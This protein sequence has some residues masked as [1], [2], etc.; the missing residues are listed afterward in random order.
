VLDIRRDRVKLGVTAPDQVKAMRHELLAGEDAG[1]YSGR[2]GPNG[3]AQ[4]KLGQAMI[5]R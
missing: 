3:T 2:R 5:R 1:G 4:V